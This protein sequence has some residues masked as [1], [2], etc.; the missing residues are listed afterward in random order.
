MRQMRSLCSWRALLEASTDR[1]WTSFFRGRWCYTF[2]R[3]FDVSPERLC[4][5]CAYQRGDQGSESSQL[6]INQLQAP[7][8]HEAEPRSRQMWWSTYWWL[9]FQ[10]VHWWT[11]TC[12]VIRACTLPKTLSTTLLLERDWLCFRKGWRIMRNDSKIPCD[13]WAYHTSR[14]SRDHPFFVNHTL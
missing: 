8:H 1:T 13:G 5:K 7:L 12:N 10:N 4:P 14:Q 6:I 2:A 9:Y 3:G 11:V